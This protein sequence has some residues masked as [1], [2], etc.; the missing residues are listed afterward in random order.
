MSCMTR[1]SAGEGRGGLLDRRPDRDH[2]VQAHHREDAEDLFAGGGD[3]QRLVSVL[4]VL[5]LTREAAE[6]GRRSSR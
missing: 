6:R 2:P 3:G 5:C 1:P 4:G